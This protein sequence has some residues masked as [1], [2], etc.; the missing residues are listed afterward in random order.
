MLVLQSHF[1]IAAALYVQQ[2]SCSRAEGND[3]ST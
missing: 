1:P 2:G 3:A